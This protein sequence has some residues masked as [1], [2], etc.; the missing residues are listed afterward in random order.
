MKRVFLISAVTI[1]ILVS[2]FTLKSVNVINRITFVEPVIN[3]DS[4]IK[5]GMPERMTNQYVSIRKSP[6]YQNKSFFIADTKENLIYFFDKNGN[7]VSKSPTIDG[8][9]KQNPNKIDEA[10][11]SSSE[12][13]NDIGF[14]WDGNK[15]QYVDITGKNRVYSHKLVYNHLG[16]TGARFFPKGVY[17]IVR[18][19]H[20]K[21]FVGN[22]D[23]TYDINSMDGKNM[24]LAI[25][26]LYQSQYRITNMNH[27]V[28][29]MGSN[30]DKIGVTKSFENTIRVNNNNGVYNNSF[31]CINVPE[32]FL[33]MT[34]DMAV[35]SLVFV[36]GESDTDYIVK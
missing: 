13:V 3:K 17:K 8:F 29:L 4:L 26:G 16:R 21:G 35:G 22:G 32:K 9:D 18:K 30:F 33:K 19:Y 24:A 20:Y 31:G 27:L 7:F 10:L 11:K 14:K 25:H 12:H 23:N 28:S 36:L 6:K 5:E 15:K 1:L 2:L 34:E